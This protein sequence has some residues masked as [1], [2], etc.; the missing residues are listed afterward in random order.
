MRKEKMGIIFHISKREQW[1]KTKLERVYRT[2]TLASQGYIHCSNSQQIVK[3]ANVKY[4]G[5]KELVLLYITTDRVQSE[6]KYENA[7]NEELY[8]HIYG[9]LNIDA[10]VNVIDFKPT[11]NGN[12][13]LPKEKIDF[14][15]KFKIR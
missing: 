2:D 9:P 1:E 8:P 13:V 15:P 4:H 6:I 11:E 3:V 5:Q 10:I 7:G 12:F 14:N